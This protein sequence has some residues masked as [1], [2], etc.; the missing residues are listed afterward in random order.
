[1]GLKIENVL[2]GGPAYGRLKKGDVILRVDGK[3][4]TEDNVLSFLR[5]NDVPGSQMLITVHRPKQAYSSVADMAYHS[6]SSTNQNADMQTRINEVNIKLTRI[7][8]SQIADRW[9]MFD[10]FTF[11]EVSLSQS[12]WW[13][14]LS[15]LPWFP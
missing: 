1:M 10:L 6:E 12:L 9:H 13:A 2:I 11:F 3:T 7:S 14:N 4:V 8:S 15:Y 5:G